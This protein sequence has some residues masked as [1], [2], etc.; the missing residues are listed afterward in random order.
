MNFVVLCCTLYVYGSYYLQ[1]M[2]MWISIWPCLLKELAIIFGKYFIRLFKDT[3]HFRWYVLTLLVWTHSLFFLWF[4][5]KQA[6]CYIPTHI[7]AMKAGRM[8]QPWPVSRYGQVMHGQAEENHKKVLVLLCILARFRPGM[9]EMCVSSITTLTKLLICT[10]F[11]Q[12]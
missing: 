7:C 2:T 9:Y 12:M 5:Y 8:K 4:L 3:C 10:I 11:T 6:I 1:T